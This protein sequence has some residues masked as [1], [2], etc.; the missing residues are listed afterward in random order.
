MIRLLLLSFCLFTT[1]LLFSQ[2]TGT[3]SG[4]LIDSVGKQ[5]LKAASISIMDPADSS[6]IVFGLSKEKGDFIFYLTN[7]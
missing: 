2:N 5:S 3:V 4:K 7:Q 6:V 1:S